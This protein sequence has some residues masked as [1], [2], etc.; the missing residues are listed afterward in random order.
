MR[1]RRVGHSGTDFRFVAARAL[2]DQGFFPVTISTDLNVF[3]LDHPVVSLPETMS[4]I[5]PSA[6]LPSVIAM[7][8]T[9]PAAVI[10]RPDRLGALAVGRVGD[11]SVL[12]VADGAV[13]LS[14][15]LRDTDHGPAP[16]CRSSC[17]RAGT[18]DPR[19]NQRRGL[20]APGPGRK[21]GKILVARLRHRLGGNGVRAAGRGPETAITI[22]ARLASR[23]LLTLL[24]TGVDVGPTVVAGR[25]A[26]A[27][28][29]WPDAWAAATNPWRQSG[30]RRPVTP[31]HLPGAGGDLGSTR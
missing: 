1:P 19:R 31:R 2:F 15:R 25:T 11:V 29:P 7:V 13:S 8:T 18:L 4:K 21:M 20:E 16:G 22:E 12:R 5:P 28:A 9:N 14:G 17:A 10:G 30:L 24:S 3:N 23:T 26:G 6:P 27:A